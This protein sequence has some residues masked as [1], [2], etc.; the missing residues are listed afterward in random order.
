M[1]GMRF[2]A[3]M[4]WLL[5]FAP[6]AAA[7]SLVYLVSYG[8]TQASFRARFPNGIFGTTTDQRLEMLRRTIKNE[9]WSVSVADG[10]RTLLFS[11]EGMSN[12]EIISATG[13]GCAIPAGGK[14]IVKGVERS[15]RGQPNP[16]AMETPRGVYEISFDGSKRFRRVMDTKE[17]MG[18]LMLD[19][20]GAKVAFDALDPATNKY[21]LYVY[22]LPGWKILLTVDLSKAMDTHC[23]GCVVQNYG[24]LADGKDLV[25]QIEPGDEDEDEASTNQVPGNYIFSDAGA[26]AGNIPNTAGRMEMTG[27]ERLPAFGARVIGQLADG[28]FVFMDYALRRVPRPKPPVEY[29]PFL[30]IT[31][32]DFKTLKQVQI[33]RL[34][35]GGYLLSANGKYMAYIED[36]MTPDYRSERYVW[37]MNLETGEAKEVFMTPPPNPPT[38]PEPNISVTIVGWSDK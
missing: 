34:R 35:T 6:L 29:E 26:D 19:A 16:G 1:N 17:N 4:M 12:F 3:V 25:F 37:T 10:K 24:W 8:T 28:R 20:S 5:I 9:I 27:Y 33:G 2:F 31:D 7:Q 18:P 30:V 11:D 38:S 13:L 21:T 15:W 23:P 36:R 14:A 22:G 32:P